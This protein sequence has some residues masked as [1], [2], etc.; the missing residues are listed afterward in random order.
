[1]TGEEPLEPREPVVGSEA[2]KPASSSSRDVVETESLE[3]IETARSRGLVDRVLALAIRRRWIV[4][5]LSI[6]LGV[7]GFLQF[8]AL[9]IDAVP[10][11]TTVQVQI[12]TVVE[13]LSPEEV[14]QQI[15]FPVENAMGGI[16]DV[17]ETRSFSRYGLSQ[18][19]VVFREGTDIY[20]A[21]QRVNERLEEA[22]AELPGDAHPE[23]GPLATALGEV[24]KWTVE[25][26]PGAKKPDGTRYTPTDLRDIQ[27]WIVKPQ[28]KNVPGVTEIS[29][30]GGFRR[31][32]HVTPDP[33]RLVPYGITFDD[34][35]Q[36][37]E[38]NNSAKG[39]GFIEHK[40]EQYLV[41]TSGRLRNSEEIR[42][43][44]VATRQGLP[45]RVR[46]V[47]AVGEGQ[48]L[49][50]GAAME[51]GEE[52]V[53][54][55]ALMLIGENSRTVAERVAERLAEVN[56][57]LPEGIV[58]RTVYSRGKLV[59]ATLETVRTNLVFGAT[60]VVLV[61]LLLLGNVRGSFIVAAVIPLSLL[62]A[63][64]GMV[65]GGISA[66]L[67]SLGAVDF[68]I[69]VDGAV[70]MVE[71]IVRRIGELQHRLGRLL[72]L[73]ER[74]QV[75]FDA[76]REVARPTLFG[77]LIIMI[78]YLPILTL[79]GIEGK[80][81]RPMA[82][83][84]LLALA[85]ALILS[86]TFVPAA[87]A[88]WLSGRVSETQS[89]PLRAIHR[90]Y[91]PALRWAL[92]RRKRV[93]VTAVVVAVLGL[94]IGTRLGSEFVPTLD[95]QDIVI[96][97]NHIPGTGLEQTLAMERDI[98]R[99]VAELPEVETVF[100]QIGTADVANDPLPPSEGDIY[101]ILKA[102]RDWPKPGKPKERLIHEIEERIDK[103]PGNLY[104]FSQPIE[105]RFNELIAGVRSDVAVE[106][107]G[108]DL[109]VLLATGKRV[110][111]VLER[112]KGS[113]DVSVEQVAGLPTL[114][115]EVDRD[116]AAR[117]GL[118]IDDIQSTVRTALAGTVAGEVLEGDRRYE[119]VVR[120]PETVRR[121]LRRLDLLPV[122]VPSLG[123]AMTTSPADNGGGS[124]RVLFVPL[125]TVAHVRLAEGPNEIRR[126]QGKRV[127]VVQSNVRGRD[128]GGF[129]TEAQRE[130]ARAVP[131]PPGY[132]IAWGGQFENLIGARKRLAVV[133]PIALLLIFLLLFGAFGSARDA[134]LV[135]S[136]VPLALTGG[137]L[138][139]AIRGMPFSI[140]AAVGFI[141]LSG[142]AVLNGIVMLSF[143]RRLRASGES[144]DRA[145]I[146]GCTA[147]LRPV[148]MTALVASLGFVPMALA[149]GTGAEVQRPLA[150]VVI[151]GIL[152]STLLTLLVLPV[153]YRLVHGGEEA[154]RVGSDA[155]VG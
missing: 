97:V 148:L 71:N 57:T 58:A 16:P 98:E 51:R 139:L 129:V 150:T 89:A 79:T 29:S 61:L 30:H 82:Q 44:V 153:L 93:V 63:I 60:L 105:D 65:I 141:A 144:L 47:A 122:P 154:R 24:F 68:G 120:L 64:T 20:F 74:L 104:E 70:V 113:A 2:T 151:G 88:L 142:V 119:I 131:V 34:I 56:R 137:V 85:G 101:V 149:T 5:L 106:I 125:G 31:Q 39:G 23:L 37:L 96:I 110:G 103:L 27:D 100:S 84:V 28:L 35:I 15:T 87:A 72:D 18:V 124:D 128:L 41:R 66:N 42:N 55:T 52:V 146:D 127:I 136:G 26:R 121:D 145:L 138:A 115:V 75:A 81:F 147:R 134:L 135:F 48:E 4:M 14:E 130:V 11:I 83:V 43:V 33:A 140:T 50:G 143:V 114:S 36:A 73:R 54:G 102:R 108:D 46:D 32:F 92:D 1:M 49:R 99:T 69:I 118:S 107:Y 62:F 76:S 38:H 25:A 109:D 8:G 17:E 90:R 21:R 152:S 19:T 9:R 94:L 117:Y 3:P 59:N 126:E 155:L 86:F 67:L 22:R 12:N 7:L 10:D 78:V 133:V 95:E 111:G 123:A 112:V 132:W 13:G 80:M 45:I 40:G 91:L 6:G 116:A 77:I 53:I